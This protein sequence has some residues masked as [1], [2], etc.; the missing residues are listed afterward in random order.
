MARSKKATRVFNN[1]D[2]PSARIA[3]TGSPRRPLL[4]P[5][6]VGCPHSGCDWH[7]SLL[8]NIPS[9]GDALG[10]TVLVFECPECRRQWN[11]DVAAPS[12]QAL[13]ALQ[14]GRDRVKI[15]SG[16]T[17]S[18]E[19]KASA[20]ASL[21]HVDQ[22]LFDSFIREIKAAAASNA[23][24]PELAYV[25]ANEGRRALGC[26]LFAVAWGRPGNR[27][28]VSVQAI[29][30][31]DP[32]PRDSPLVRAMTT[33]FDQVIQS[34][35][36]LVY[37]GTGDDSLSPVVKEALDNYLSATAVL[38]PTR[39]PAAKFLAI[40]PHILASGCIAFMIQ[41]A[42]PLSRRKSDIWLSTLKLLSDHTT[43]ALRN[44]PQLELART[45][46]DDADASNSVGEATGEAETS[47][48]PEAPATP[49]DEQIVN[50]VTGI[51]RGQDDAF[52]ALKHLGATA[53]P[54]LIEL[55]QHGH[56]IFGAGAVT[57]LGSLGPQ[58]KAALPALREALTRGSQ[59]IRCRLPMA[60]AQIAQADAVPDLMGM[61]RNPDR[62]VRY[63]ALRA[64]SELIGREATV[65]LA[66]CRTL[67][68]PTD[69]ARLAIQAALTAFIGTNS[70]VNTLERMQNEIKNIL[71]TPPDRGPVPSPASAYDKLLADLAAESERHQQS[72]A[73]RFERVLNA[74]LQTQAP[75]NFK[76]KHALA[77]R[78]TADLKSLGL[79]I[80]YPGSDQPCT[81]VA[82][83]GPA[84]RMGVF[85]IMARGSKTA[86]LTKA[87]LHDLL[88]LS[89]MP[90]TPRREA[91]T[92]WRQRIREAEGQ[93]ATPDR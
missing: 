78:V 54:G 5:Y 38:D 61:L 82:I 1:P 83:H 21:P 77:Q 16:D 2:Q 81:L 76:D 32:I 64:L 73:E 26:D 3:D 44:M 80:H 60:L 39:D 45:L 68:E 58:A 35:Q 72:V 67:L 65:S 11:Y 91:F 50:L 12:E 66:L 53:V 37:N 51:F 69:Q 79:A 34:G 36:A 84:N 92:E 46:L 15:V 87:N 49:T 9:L 8:P 56:S 48:E 40:Y 62:H 88:P 4:S 31:A 85:R 63:A 30:A 70:L 74:Y 75:E 10:P 20:A 23:P 89:L 27:D 90:A 47:T 17:L 71:G 55:L 41:C 25:V 7:G 42:Q 13:R 43:D 24:L 22:S 57:A 52:V 18:A 14:L 33:L 6:L 86:L 59:E 29:S 93:A 19:A 28:D